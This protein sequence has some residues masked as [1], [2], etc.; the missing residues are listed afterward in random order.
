MFAGLI[1]VTLLNPAN[2]QEYS[3]EQIQNSLLS[4]PPNSGN[5]S[6]RE[7]MILSLDSILKDK[8][9]RKSQGVLDFYSLMMKMLIPKYR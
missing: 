2:A 4:N 9:S 7:E 1:L 3:L 6:I 8:A 5:Q